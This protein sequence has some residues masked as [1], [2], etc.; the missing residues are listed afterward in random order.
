MQTLQTTFSDHTSA[1]WA[2]LCCFL[3]ITG[4]GLLLKYPPAFDLNLKKT[5]ISVSAIHLHYLAS[6]SHHE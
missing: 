5:Q 3:R 1:K 2:R 4:S 6:D